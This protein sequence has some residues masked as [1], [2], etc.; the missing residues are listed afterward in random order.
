MTKKSKLTDTLITSGFTVPSNYF[1]N[2]EEDLLV[3]LSLKHKVQDSGFKVP[4]AYFKT[5]EGNVIEHLSTNE[6]R[7][8]RPLFNW[9][10]AL[11][12]TAAAAV[13]LLFMFTIY[14]NT[15]ETL[16]LESLDSVSIEDYLLD[17]GLTSYELSVLLSDQ[18]LIIDQ[19]TSDTISED[20]L[21]TYLLD[22]SEIEYLITK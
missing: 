4:E 16:T 8:V 15:S 10:K 21:E 19:Y 20:Q 22:N 3:D 2:I 17:E 6:D 14:F 5:L 12:P 13:L 18:E 11:Y 1:S 9:E 7:T